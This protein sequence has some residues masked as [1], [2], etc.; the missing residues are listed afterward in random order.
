MQAFKGS[1][2]FSFFQ[3]LMVIQHC[4]SAAYFIMY[5]TYYSG[6]C[7]ESC[8][9]VTEIGVAFLGLKYLYYLVYTLIFS[10]GFFTSASACSC[11]SNVF[12]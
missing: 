7:S 6:S 10:C 2:S 11:K 1:K 4:S 12:V 9:C 8:T 5:F 3:L